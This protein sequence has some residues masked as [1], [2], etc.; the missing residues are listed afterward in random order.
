LPDPSLRFHVVVG[1]VAAFS[2]SLEKLFLTKI[3]P[4]LSIFL[5][6][7]RHK[8]GGWE[9]TTDDVVV[10]VSQDWV[11]ACDVQQRFYAGSGPDQ[12]FGGLQRALPPSSSPRRRLQ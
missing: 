9:M 7:N 2:T 3:R 10:D 8:S 11:L 12:R 5:T 4:S 1:A 6:Q